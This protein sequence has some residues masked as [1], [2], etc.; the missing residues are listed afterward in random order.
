MASKLPTW[1]T[2]LETF[3][4]VYSP[5]YDSFRSAHCDFEFNRLGYGAMQLAGRFVWGAPKDRAS[6]IALLREAVALGVNHIDTAD[7]YG[8][9]VTNEIIREAL[10]PYG[11][12]LRI[13]TKVGFL[14]GA[15]KSWIPAYSPQQL[16][17]AVYSNLRNLGLEVLDLVN[18]RA[19]GT[20]GPDGSSI[21]EALSAL[22]DMKREGLIR[23]MGVSNVD[24]HQVEE[25]LRITNIVCVQNHYNLVRRQD[26]VMIDWL[27]GQGIA[28]VP[29]FPL[30]GFTP[31]KSA[32]LAAVAASL[33]ATPMQV[34]LAW[35]LQRSP[36][37][38]L[39]PGT[40][41]LE[42]LRENIAAGALKLDAQ[43]LAALDQI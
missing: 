10:Q 27:A 42:H 24:Q 14:R 41:S 26:D 21:A 33:N 20:A 22:V 32:A 8:P 43:V 36:N 7:F 35:L 40:S 23:Y 9:Y 3:M 16:R 17:D 38:L 30:G 39:I 1:I 28:Y 2:I 11:D 12:E 25:A 29:F 4:S 37:I 34:A 19:P 5:S 31:L 18:L 15:D 6:A 13:V